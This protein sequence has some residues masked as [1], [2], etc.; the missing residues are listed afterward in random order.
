M[1]ITGPDYENLM[2]RFVEYLGDRLM[3]K[4]DRK[5]TG[6]DID[7]F[8]LIDTDDI[9]KWLKSQKNIA[10]RKSNWRVWWLYI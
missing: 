3:E 10:N 9:Y 4:L 6:K 8:P 1:M 5:Y 7:D 2:T